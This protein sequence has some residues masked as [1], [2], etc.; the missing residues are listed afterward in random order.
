LGENG[1]IEQARTIFESLHAENPDNRDV[2]FALGLLALEEKNG[3]EA[4]SFF[5]QL[6]KLGDPSHQAAYFIGLSEEVNGNIDAAL[7]WFASVPVQSIRF[8]AAQTKYI[9]LL[10]DRGEIDKARDHLK[11]L[12]KEQ[13]QQALQY[14]LFEAGFLREQKMPQAAFDLYGEALIL[15]PGNEELLYSRAMVSESLNRLDV[16]ESDLNAI[17]EKDPNN[18]QALNALGYTLADRTE[19]YQEALQLINKALALKPGD[20]FYLDSLGWVYYRLGDLEKAEQYLREA[21]DVQ[22]DVEFIAHLGEVLWERGKQSEAMSIWQ[23]GLKQDADNK[24]LI[25]T[26]RRYGK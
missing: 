7:V 8:D 25:E 12:R 3:K 2:L 11:L 18:A 16:L 1:Q 14:Y 15:Y 22:P 17:L 6:L 26:M 19:R 10:A 23:Q 21:M 24:L 20:P 9:N 5:S 13:P 4:K